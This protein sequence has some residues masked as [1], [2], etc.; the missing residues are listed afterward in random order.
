[1]KFLLAIAMTTTLMGTAFGACSTS[2]LKE[3]TTEKDCKGLSVTDGP[4]YNLE[5]TK[6]D[7]MVCRVKDT[8]IATNCT[9]NPNGARTPKPGSDAAAEKAKDATQ[10]R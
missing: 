9:E 7:G 2:S 5:K 6:D 1:M 3:C 10:A 8:A 4:Q